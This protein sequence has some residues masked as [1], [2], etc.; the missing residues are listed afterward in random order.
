[1]RSKNI[2]NP[3][4]AWR[5]FFKNVCTM[6]L[7]SIPS[8]YTTALKNTNSQSA[9]ELLLSQ[10]TLLENLRKAHQGSYGIILSLLGCL[11]H[12]LGAKKLV[13]KVIDASACHHIT[14]SARP[15]RPTTISSRSGD[16][17]TGG[18]S[19]SPVTLF[20][21]KPKRRTGRNIFEQG[22]QGFGEI[23]RLLTT[24]SFQLYSPINVSFFMIVFASFIEASDKDFTQS[25]LDWITVSYS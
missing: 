2:V 9:I 16:E 3:Y 20:P 21:H 19:E 12:G 7:F 8:W 23:V 15:N 25:F 13:D 24:R 10:P 4:Y 5:I 1:M 18:Y 14:L 17:P 6:R 11:D 22:S